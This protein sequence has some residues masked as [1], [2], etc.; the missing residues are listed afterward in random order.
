M[1]S[2]YRLLILAGVFLS[3]ALS[4]WI[5]E[6]DKLISFQAEVKGQAEIQQQIIAKNEEWNKQVI[7]ESTNEYQ[8]RIAA[9]N[10]KYGRLHNYCSSEL[11]SPNSERNTQGAISSTSNDVPAERNLIK[12]CAE[13]TNTLITLQKML[14][15]TKEIE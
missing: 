3:G 1:L 7:K 12:D 9:I 15:Q 2:S 10:T 8:R 14:I 5:Y 11:P 13:T 6:H 4:G